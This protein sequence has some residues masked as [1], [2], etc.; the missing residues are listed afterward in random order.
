MNSQLKCNLSFILKMGY[1][2]TSELRSENCNLSQ[3]QG[4]LMIDSSSGK[5]HLRHMN[6]TQE[7][8][9]TRLKIFLRNK[10]KFRERT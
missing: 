5:K 2:V 9:E 10:I 6:G 4:K 3:N 1:L 8:L 7:K